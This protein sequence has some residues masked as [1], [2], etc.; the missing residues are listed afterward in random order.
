M[1]KRF[2]VT[3]LAVLLVVASGILLASREDEAAETLPLG[4]TVSGVPMPLP[5]AEPPPTGEWLYVIREYEGRVAVFERS[6]PDTP[7]IVYDTLVKFL[8][9]YDRAALREGIPVKDLGELVSRVED[10][11]S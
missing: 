9:D 4:E 5:G 7:E 8:P 2:A 10:Y 11:I 3:V 6:A 1:D